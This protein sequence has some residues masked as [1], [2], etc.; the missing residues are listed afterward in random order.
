MFI[1]SLTD[2]FLRGNKSDL[3]CGLFLS[4]TIAK[5]KKPQETNY[6]LFKISLMQE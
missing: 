2:E 5:A 1:H 4:T 3:S 6:R